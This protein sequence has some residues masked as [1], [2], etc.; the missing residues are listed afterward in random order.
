M[1]VVTIDRNN[2]SGKRPSAK[3]Q[4]KIR[5]CVSMFRSLNETVNEIVEL[6]RNEGFSPKEIGQFI[7]EETLKSGLSRRKLQTIYLQNWN[8]NKGI[9][10]KVRVKISQNQNRAQVNILGKTF[11]K[12]KHQL[13]SRRPESLS[14]KASKDRLAFV[15]PSKENKNLKRFI[16]REVTITLA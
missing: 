8:R 13:Q 15:F 14:S 7:R 12:R 3:L 11:P 4:E 16:G 2:D 6:G 1:Q 9:Q 5:T 10:V